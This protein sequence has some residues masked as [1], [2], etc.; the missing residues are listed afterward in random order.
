MSTSH[1]SHA[2]ALAGQCYSP[3]EIAQAA[4]VTE[5]QVLTAL[6]VDVRLG[7]PPSFVTHEDAVAIGRALHQLHHTQ[8]APETTDTPPRGARLFSIFV[9]GRE[10]RA[11]GMPLA[12]SSTLHAG[13]FVAV[14]FLTTVGLTPAAATDVNTRFDSLPLV[15]VA[16]P[17]PGGGG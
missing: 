1:S 11:T 7:G 12:L 3:R 14:V 13:L 15:F 16:L 4:G 17:G 9:S 2:S 10:A 8:A 6:G 5:Q